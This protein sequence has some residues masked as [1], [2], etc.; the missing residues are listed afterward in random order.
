MV[1]RCT[2]MDHCLKIMYRNGMY[3]KYLVPIWIYPV[4]TRQ[5]RKLYLQPI[6]ECLLMTC[7]KNYFFFNWWMYIKV[8]A[9]QTW[10]IF[11]TRRGGAPMGAGGHDPH[12]SRQRGTGGHNLGIIHISHIALVTP[13]HQ[14]QRSV[15]FILACGASHRQLFS[16]W[17]PVDSEITAISPVQGNEDYYLRTK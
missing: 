7:A 12:F 11:E 13:L 15:V 16:D 9:S 4:I 5:L 10:Y 2:E 8:I 3:R 17:R 1:Y 14:R 6:F